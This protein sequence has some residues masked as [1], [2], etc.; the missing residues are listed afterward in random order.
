MTE[1]GSSWNINNVTWESFNVP[2]S[3]LAQ[4]Q[5][6]TRRAVSDL[7]QTFESQG[8]V[9]LL[10]DLT[11]RVR[12][13][14]G[15]GAEARMRTTA[16]AGRPT[17][18]M[19][20][21]APSFIPPG[22]LTMIGEPK[23][24]RYVHKTIV[25]ELSMLFLWQITRRKTGGWGF[26]AGRDWL[27][28]GWEEYLA[29]T[30]STEHARFVTLPLYRRQVAARW[31]GGQPTTI[32]RYLDGAIILHFM[33]ERFGQKTMFE[34]LRSTQHTFAAALISTLHRDET[35][36]LGEFS[37]WIKSSAV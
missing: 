19:E 30:T 3:D 25:H 16:V 36:L 1:S 8:G 34:L 37:S 4:V 27:V 18:E 12:L 5:E 9:S 28:D 14:R 26:F 32:D 10:V 31:A 22:A 24:A 33:H 11:L 35:Q 17:A 20:L 13:H 7:C 23:N 15:D 2:E 6:F 29:L 21:L